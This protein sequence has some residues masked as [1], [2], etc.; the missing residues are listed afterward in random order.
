MRIEEVP[1]AEEVTIEL[2][3]RPQDYENL[4]R[5]AKYV[6]A[7]SKYNVL[8]THFVCSAENLRLLFN[9]SILLIAFSNDF[10]ADC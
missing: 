8:A 10:I 7:R 4:A 3:E 6:R 5:A 1:E 9:N 2:G